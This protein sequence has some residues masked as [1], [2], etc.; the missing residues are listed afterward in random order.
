MFYIRQYRD[1]F[2]ARTVESKCT[3]AARK[4]NPPSINSWLVF[5]LFIYLYINNNSRTN[6]GL[7]GSYT[8]NPPPHSQLP[9]FSFYTY[10]PSTIHLNRIQ[11]LKKGLSKVQI[12]SIYRPLRYNNDCS[13]KKPYR[14]ADGNNR[15][16]DRR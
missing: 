3:E 1:T 5:S 7:D 9:F 16:T 4:E 13:E 11:N 12:E 6:V 15:E 14:L 10:T 8:T 2:K